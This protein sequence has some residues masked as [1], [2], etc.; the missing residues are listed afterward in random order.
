[1]IYAMANPAVAGQAFVVDNFMLTPIPETDKRRPIIGLL[2]VR[3][4][5]LSRRR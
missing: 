5:G 2:D 1:M 3:S 4:L